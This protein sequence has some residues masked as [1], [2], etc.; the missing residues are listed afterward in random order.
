[1]KRQK[2][3]LQNIEKLI[4]PQLHNSGVIV[5]PVDAT[6][7]QHAE[8]YAKYPESVGYHHIEIELVGGDS[9]SATDRA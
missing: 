4:T 8:L 9:D 1:M 3:R 5:H 6:P 2:T 7:K